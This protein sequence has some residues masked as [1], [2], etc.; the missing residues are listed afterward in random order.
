MKLEV[1]FKKNEI[2]L[3]PSKESLTLGQGIKI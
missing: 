3:N 2:Y 1:D